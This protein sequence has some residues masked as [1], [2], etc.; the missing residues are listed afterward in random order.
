M[1]TTNLIQRDGLITHAT[2]TPATSATMFIFT[3]SSVANVAGVA[4]ATS[5]ITK[6]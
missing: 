6:D 3:L 2:A 5:L 1:S 4:V